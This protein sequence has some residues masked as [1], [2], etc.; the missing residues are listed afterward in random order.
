[1]VADK[2]TYRQTVVPLTHVPRVN[3]SN[4]WYYVITMRSGFKLN[5]GALGESTVFP[6]NLAVAGFYFKAL[7][8]VA[9]I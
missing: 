2:Y 5:E 8:D 7:F 6:Q 9:T 1:M 3:D 4:L